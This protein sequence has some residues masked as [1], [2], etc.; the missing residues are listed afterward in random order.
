MVS[1]GSTANLALMSALRDP[2]DPVPLRI[3]AA[4]VTWPTNVTP[5]ML[6]GHETVL[7]DVDRATLGIDTAVTTKAIEANEVNVVF[8]THLLGFNALSQDLVEVCSAHEVPILEDCC[9]AHGARFGEKKVGSVGHGSTFSFYFGHHMSTVEG[10]MINTDN[11][12]LADRLRMIRNHGMA[13]SSRRFE[14]YARENPTIDRRFLFVLAGM[15]YRSTEINAFLGLRQLDLIDG[16]I[17]QRNANLRRFLEEAPEWIWTDYEIEG[18]SSFALPL[19][20][21]DQIGFEKASLVVN[22]LGIESRPVVAGNLIA[23]PFARQ[24]ARLK[25]RPDDLPTAHHIHQFGLYVGNGHHVTP[26]MVSDL[27]TALRKAR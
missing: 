13:R 23:Q 2:G 1:S 18:V 10:G 15:N 11:D 5:G 20:S 17:D 9:E 14:E 19:I 24:F 3:G 27:C 25:A 16:R 7:L 21:M 8:V 4:A 22:E 6:L 26:D 12:D